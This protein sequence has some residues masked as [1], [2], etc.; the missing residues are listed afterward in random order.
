MAQS[1]DN[2]VFDSVF[3]TLVHKTP[4]LILPLINEAF[5]RNYPANE[6]IIQFSNEHEG[7]RGATISDSVFRV[8]DK[9]YHLECQ[10][11]PD[12]NMVVRMIE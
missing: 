3:K 12:A 2:T 7:P 6:P 11:T 8:K 4:E 10:S 5:G 9:I 1:S